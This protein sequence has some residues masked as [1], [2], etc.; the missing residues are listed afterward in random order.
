MKVTT[1]KLPKSLLSL[2]VEIDSAQVEK[3]LDRAARRVSQKYNIPGF[4]KGKAPRFIVENYFGRE[5]LVEEASEDL[6]NRSFKEALEQENIEP[7]GQ[8]NLEEANFQEEPYHFRATIP[9]APTVTIPDYRAIQVPA[10]LREVT[11]E[12]VQQALDT[13]REEHVVLREPEDPRP[14]QQGDQL[15]VKLE[16]FVDDEPLDDRNEEGEIPEST[17]VLEPDRLA[18]GLFDGLIGIETEETRE[19]TVR[20]PEDHPNEQIR[21][22]D[23]L[24]K[25]NLIS[26]QERLLPDWEELPTLEEFEGTLDELRDKTRKELEETAE[27]E[28]KRT[29]VD[30][31]VKQLTEQ[32]EYDIADAMIQR[33]AERLLQN[34][35][36]SFE[37]YGI[38]LDQMLQYRNQTREDAAKELLPQAEEQLKTTLAL[39]EIVRSEQLSIDESEIEEEVTRVL[40]SYQEEERDAIRNMLSTQ[41]RPSIANN[42][43]NQKLM[44]R[45]FLIATGA[46]PELPASADNGA[47]SDDTEEKPDEQEQSVAGGSTTPSEVTESRE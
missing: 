29:T 45:L 46:A 21:D 41:L 8:A 26:L 9:V 38:T 43:L 18:E 31:Y 25:I 14:A 34:Q 44:E 30:E 5:T 39:G 4:R 10:E 27:Q 16:S 28:M 32:T 33:E 11:D 6:I 3:G 20:M 35:A 17:M 40:D 12:M 47:A 7:I 22:K 1:E 19:I 23:V 37:R 2:T 13:R 15:T 42:V 24:F 36:Q